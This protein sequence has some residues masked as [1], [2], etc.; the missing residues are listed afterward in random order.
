MALLKDCAFRTA[1]Y[2]SLPG[3]ENRKFTPHLY[4]AAEIAKISAKHSG[5]G[6]IFDKVSLLD[7]FKQ[8][9]FS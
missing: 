6:A 2:R 8:I 1:I 5:L 4:Q 9:C 3:D 7:D